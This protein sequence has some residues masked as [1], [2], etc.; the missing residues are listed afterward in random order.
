MAEFGCDRPRDAAVKH[1]ISVK[2]PIRACGV[3]AV[4]CFLFFLAGQAFIPLLGIQNDEAIFAAPIYQKGSALYY[5]R[6]GHS[7]IPLM[8]M[9]YLGT[10][11]TL[12]YRPLFAVFGTN[13]WT[14]REPAVVAGSLSLWLFFI[15]LR[16]SMGIRAAVIGCGLLAAD[17]LYLLTTCYDWGPVALQHLL[18]LGGA[19]L[20]L[21]FYRT[22]S[23]AGGFFLFGLALWDKALAVWMLSGLGIAALVVYPRQILRSITPRRAALAA[24]ALALGALPLILFNVHTHLGT[25]RQ[26]AVRDTRSIPSK[27]VFILKTADGS[28]LLSWLNEENWQTPQPH[29]PDDPLQEVS[30][31]LDELTNHPR[32][33]LM[34]YA[35]VL[36][37]LLTPLAGR[38]A[39][40]AIAF[41]LIAFAVA[42]IQMASTA[43]TGASIHHTILL[44][45]LP[46]AIV[47]ISFAG[48]SRRLGRGA[49]AALA[50]VMGLLVLSQALVTNEYYAK[51]VRNGG[52]ANWSRALYTLSDYLRSHPAPV[53]YCMD[54][55]YTNNLALLDRGKLPL[56]MGTDSPSDDLLAHPEAVFVAHPKDAESFEG[57]NE[58]LI[59]YAAQ[60]GYRKRMLASI[61]DEFGR[62]V[63][64]I[65]QFAK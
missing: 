63:F 18:L 31:Q 29:T 57:V 8:L 9:S 13:V 53:V 45:P 20:T 65:Y 28:G 17:S 46:Q 52:S 5:Y 26:N 44:W 1:F 33:S 34:P 15:F 50:A 41:C 55:G 37:L 60:K 12:I 36:A 49:L 23:V 35:I 48:A 21:N 4:F 47:A 10:L 56:A 58:K 3:A 6:L 30:A 51:L 38:D 43:N 40:R 59:D 42:W 39:A 64:E 16:R 32:H 24:A 22:A 2:H 11:K 14:L 25:L 7:H 54:W 62:P 19:V 61:P 27:A